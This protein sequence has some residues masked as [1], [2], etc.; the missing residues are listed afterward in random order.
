MERFAK[1][2]P[3]VISVFCRSKHLNDKNAIYPFQMWQGD[4]ALDLIKR[5]FLYEVDE[6]GNDLNKEN[7]EDTASSSFEDAAK[8]AF[9][10]R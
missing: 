2:V 3:G 7:Q 1:I 8:K 6:E 10:K 9:K 4:D 5:G